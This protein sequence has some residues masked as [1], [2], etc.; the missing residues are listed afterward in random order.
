M[1]AHWEYLCR[2]QIPEK[3]QLANIQLQRPHD[4][5]SGRNQGNRSTHIGKE[6]IES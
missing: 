4:Q 1:K 3:L 6:N 2:L 5:Q